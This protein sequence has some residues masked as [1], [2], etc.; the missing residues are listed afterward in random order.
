MALRIGF[1]EARAFDRTHFD[2][3]NARFGYELV[4]FEP[5]L[6]IDTVKLAAGF[7][8]V[9]CFVNDRLDADTIRALRA[10]GTELVALRSAGYNQVDLR[11][12]KEHGITVVRVP[13]YS[14]HA[15]AEHAVA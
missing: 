11:A 5:R 14:P 9:C 1:F 13:E 12:A 4:Y 10:G 8:V 15:V 2:G 6:T 7:R 3:A